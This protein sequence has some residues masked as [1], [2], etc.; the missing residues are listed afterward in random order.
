MSKLSSNII[1]KNMYV[2]YMLTKTKK[3][4]SCHVPRGSRYSGFSSSSRGSPVKPAMITACTAVVQ[5]EKS[6]TW[7]K[8]PASGCF[9]NTVIIVNANA[10]I[11]HKK[12]LMKIMRS[13]ERTRVIDIIKT[14]RLMYGWTSWS[15][16][17]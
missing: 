12:M 1:D 16:K 3:F 8:G 9:G 10:R 4:I 15:K 5:C 13:P 2:T 11:I 14:E 6:A 17:A 7:G